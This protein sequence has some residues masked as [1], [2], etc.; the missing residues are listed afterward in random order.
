[1]TTRLHVFGV[2]HHGPGSAAS[3][4]RALNLVDPDEVLIEG[5]PE[6]SALI[7]W[8]KHDMVPP[9]ALLVYDEVE[10][11]RAVFYPYAEFSPEWQAMRWALRRGRPVRFMDLPVATR[12]K[13]LA[14]A[15]APV[16]DDAAEE[17]PVEPEPDTTPSAPPVDPLG[18]LAAMAGYDDGEAW[19]NS[20]VEESEGDEALFA[21][22]EAAMAGVRATGPLRRDDPRRE[23][24]MRE[25][26]AE[27]LAR[28]PGPVAAVVGAWHAPALREPFGKDDRA[29]VKAARKGAK[30]TATWVPWTDSRLGFA[31][32]YGAG[33]RAPG[34]YAA[35]WEARESAS[36]ELLTVRWQTR[37][38]RALR[39]R[40]RPAATSSIIDAVRLVDALA[41]LRGRAR[42]GLDEMR[43]AS[44]ATLCAGDE[45]PWA[46]VAKELLEGTR[47]GVVP[48]DV[49]ATPLAADLARHQKALKLKA[50]A[51]PRELTIDLRSDNGGARSRLL[52]RLA[53]LG[54]PW[55]TLTDA[56]GSRGTFR[57]N[58]TLCWQ[59]ELS[60]KLAEALRWGTTIDGAAA[61]RLEHELQTEVHPGKLAESV[62]GALLAGLDAAVQ[63]GVRRIDQVATGGAEIAALCATVPPL[64][65]VLRYGTARALRLEGV[66]ELV[67]SL[68]DK[69]DVGLQ[70]AAR[71]LDADAATALRE[72]LGQL[73]PAVRLYRDGARLGDWTDALARVADDPDAAALVAGWATRRVHDSGAWSDEQVA[74]RLSSTLSPGVPLPRAAAWLEGFL[75]EAAHILLHDAKLLGLVDAWLLALPEEGLLEALPLLRRATASFGVSER[76]RLLKMVAGALRGTRAAEVPTSSAAFEGGVALLD[77]ILGLGGST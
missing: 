1:M 54:V 57:E 44:L 64:V 73:D 28:V 32:G 70:H 71:H 65:D 16:A 59:P 45:A 41:A 34:W 56:G 39:K 15:E 25:Q 69:V 21:A 13:E 27:A 66:D 30:V 29:L 20:L 72:A 62:R 8:A 23:A 24:H 49:P 10:P 9:V 43:D 76:Q 48:D 50:E 68:L 75:G 19:W 52:H 67:S 46:L 61:A 17:D 60:I 77:R 3:V 53:V 5:P 58:W 4:L 35:L 11:R 2:R 7:E 47:I 42:P 37:V 36:P 18:R 38:A 51:E 31:S 40:D 22:V 6:G 26:V 63:A 12:L 55:G 14:D 33:V 74:A